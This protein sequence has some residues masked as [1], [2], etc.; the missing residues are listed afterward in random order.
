MPVLERG[1][2]S[3]P[4]ILRESSGE[5]LK[6]SSEIEAV[7][8]R[9]LAARIDLDVEAMRNLHST[10]DY[11]RLIGSD[12]DE[13]TQGHDKVIQIWAD[14]RLFQVDS[15]LL[16]IEAFENG[17]TGWA[18]VEQE[19]TLASGQTFIFRITMVLQL[20]AS[21]WKVVQL[22]FSVPVADE[23][24]VGVELTRTLSDLLTSMDT[25]SASLANGEAILGTSTILFTDLVDSTALSQSLGDRRWS[26]LIMIHFKTVQEVVEREGGSVVKT[27]GD[28]GMY[29]FASGASA[30]LA[31]VG[32]QRAVTASAE[33]GLKLRV[34]V[35][36]GDVI[37]SQDDYLGL[38]VNKAAR[39]AAAAEGGQILV[40]STT[41]DMVHSAELE[42]GD[43]IT[44]ELKG[45]D[46]T[47]ILRPLRWE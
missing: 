17:E 8:R 7:V 4:D 37:Q 46:G 36:T 30:L 27:V 12:R 16:R 9:F 22:H 6:Q 13:W 40:S 26:D 34:G 15:K 10:S 42:F 20:E 33:D 24:I 21:V 11:V 41:I 5:Q 3:V 1:R 35:H 43:P 32:I 19:R 25:E 29:V 44:A 23:E 14:H 47:H 38:T 2:P 28:G 45:L 31:A 39:V 18:A